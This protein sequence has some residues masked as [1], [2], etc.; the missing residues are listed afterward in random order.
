MKE[1]EGT[2]V[3][4]WMWKV[5]QKEREGADFFFLIESQTRRVNYKNYHRF[6]MRTIL[7]LVSSALPGMS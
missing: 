3:K 1:E 4:V 6:P 2:V 5:R 7:I